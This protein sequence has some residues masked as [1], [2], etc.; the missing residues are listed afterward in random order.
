[1]NENYRTGTEHTGMSAAMKGGELP[2]EDVGKVCGQK[3]QSAQGTSGQTTG[4]Q[5]HMSQTSGASG[6]GGSGGQGQTGTQTQAGMGGAGG[7]RKCEVNQVLVLGASG[8]VGSELVKTLSENYSCK[9]LAGMHDTRRKHEKSQLHKPNVQIVEANMK[10]CGSL[11]KAIPKGIESVFINTTSTIDRDMVTC[12]TIDCC[13][14]AGARHITV[15][16]VASLDYH[17]TIFGKQFSKIENHL[18]SCGTPYT[19]LRCPLFIDN[20]K[21]NADSI[22]RESKF[23]GPCRPDARFTPIAICD[24][25][26]AAGCIVAN[27]SRHANKVYRLTTTPMCENDAARALSSLLGKDIKYI[28]VPY[29]QFRASMLSFGMEQ[30]MADGI[31][32]LKHHIDEGAPYYQ[33]SADFK[34]IT[35]RDP[36]TL[37]QWLHCEAGCFK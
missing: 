14:E 26:E 32:E 17:N 5:S 24:V 28:Q 7:M 21:M 2:Q 9:I 23:Y 29:D 36:T 20:L 11:K 13:K 6:V 12:Q 8:N 15:I 33:A 3:M 31:I 22:K 34:T 19:V 18:K 10:D 30:W 37:E 1:M 16:S 25:A 27:P 35:G 4:G